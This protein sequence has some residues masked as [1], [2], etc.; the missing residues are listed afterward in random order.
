[1]FPA[2][3]KKPFA[4][5][6]K[7]RTKLCLA[8]FL[9]CRVW[10]NLLFRSK[11]EWDFYMEKGGIK[12]S[13]AAAPA[14]IEKSLTKGAIFCL[15]Q[16]MSKSNDQKAH[17]STWESG[18]W[19]YFHESHGSC[20]LNLHRIVFRDQSPI[21]N[22]A[23]IYSFPHLDNFTFTLG[24]VWQTC[25]STFVNL[26]FWC[27]TSLSLKI[28]SSSSPLPILICWLGCV[29]VF[30]RTLL[31]LFDKGTD[32]S[33]RKSS[34]KIGEW[35]SLDNAKRSSSSSSIPFSASFRPIWRQLK[36]K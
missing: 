35:P 29:C 1:M 21:S 22:P 19:R 28:V 30:A 10:Q 4:T 27:E 34:W 25:L 15:N 16:F 5:P 26:N 11:F 31:S 32:L 7:S 9:F 13:A 36:L 8:L 12:L 14:W 23:M 20:S 2:K 33:R 18:R 24:F 17:Y 6:C 3:K